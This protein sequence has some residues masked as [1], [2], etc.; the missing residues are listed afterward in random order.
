MLRMPFTSLL[1]KNIKML[2]LLWRMLSELQNCYL[3]ANRIRSISVCSISN[4]CQAATKAHSHDRLLF[5]WFSQFRCNSMALL[6]AINHLGILVIELPTNSLAK[7]TRWLI[8]YLR[9]WTF[10]FRRFWKEFSNWI[11]FTHYL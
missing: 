10:S 8:F 11:A 6:H 1:P 9:K 7:L 2:K 3:W 5:E 4:H